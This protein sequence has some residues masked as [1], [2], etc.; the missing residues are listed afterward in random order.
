MKRLLEEIGSKLRS[1]LLRRT[2]VYTFSASLN[3]LVAFLLLPVL[4]RYL[5]PYDYGVV[6]TFLAA[7]ACLTGVVIVGGNTLLAKEY[8][9]LINQERQDY[10]GNILGVTLIS[11]LGLMALFFIFSR[12]SE[13]L[14]GVLKISNTLILI[15]IAVALANAFTSMVLTL[16]QLERKAKSYAFFINSRSL[17]DITI[18]LVCVV[19]LGMNWQGRIIGIS[20]TAMIFA[21][22]AL[23]VFYSEN[24]KIMF[25]SRYGKQILLL[26]APLIIA[27]LTGWMNEMVGKIMI[28]G[29]LNPESTGLYS[30]GYR[31]GM[32]VMMVETAFSLAWLPFFYEGIKDNSY[33]QNL[34][35]VKVTYIYL[36]SLFLFAFIFGLGA[37]YLLFF[38]VAKN[39]YESSQFIFLI[40]MAYFFDG[41]WKTFIG[42]LIYQGKTKTYSNIVL[43]AAI[44]N[45]GL[46]YILLKQVGLIG[47][48]WAT[49]IS[50]TVGALLTVIM[51]I[52]CHPMPWTLRLES[53][54]SNN[55]L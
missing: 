9:G 12:F 26:G 14:S 25:P 48:A 41:V 13:W 17:V 51:G 37:K 53:S 54:F 31:F 46:N 34:K 36:I 19:A 47:S 49:L 33:S 39:F 6:E 52:R 15:I 30:I 18:S 32:V 21:L 24:V 3:S 4:T 1:G 29:I 11:G 38:M 23:L 8:F 42:Y 44:I 35:I 10:I 50:F 22:V 5:T 45:V 43:I 40:S 2:F 27:H 7:A 16:F 55:G 28:T 20:A